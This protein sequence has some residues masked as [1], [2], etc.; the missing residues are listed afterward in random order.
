MSKLDDR[1]PGGKP[2]GTTDNSIEVYFIR[3]A[4]EVMHLIGNLWQPG[5]GAF[6]WG[7]E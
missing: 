6:K 3:K 1:A 2:P 4:R 5:V 7:G